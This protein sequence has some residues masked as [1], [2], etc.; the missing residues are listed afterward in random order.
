ME[1]FEGALCESEESGSEIER[2]KMRLS[3]C[4]FLVSE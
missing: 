4:E 2:E 3:E 1:Y